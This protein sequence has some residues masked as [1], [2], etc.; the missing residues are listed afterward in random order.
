LALSPCKYNP[1]YPEHVPANFFRFS[2]LKKNL[3]GV[4]MS[5]EE[6][7]KEWGQLLRSILKEESIRDFVR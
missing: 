4:T 5:P 6:F 1:Y 3:A 7:M 2:K